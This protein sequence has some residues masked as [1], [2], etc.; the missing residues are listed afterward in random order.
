VV[1]ATK[2][3]Q[4]SLKLREGLLVVVFL[5]GLVTLCSLQAY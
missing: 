2:E 5:A 4:D 3:F 1:V